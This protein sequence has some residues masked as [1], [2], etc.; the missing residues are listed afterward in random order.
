MGAAPTEP[1]KLYP[2]H[3][4]V[5]TNYRLPA[6]VDRCNLEVGD[7]CHRCKTL[8]DQ[9]IIKNYMYTNSILFFIIIFIEISKILINYNN[10]H[11][12]ELIQN[13]F[14]LFSD[15]SPMQS[16]RSFFSV[17]ARNSTECHS[18]VATK[19]KDVFGCFNSFYTFYLYPHC[20]TIVL[21]CGTDCTFLLRG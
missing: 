20:V 15:I 14:F 11:N 9:L 18:G 13:F 6:D 10:Y 4:L 21:Y 8:F 1:P 19:S 3:L 5:I 16:L 7:S 12:T 2:Y 17:L